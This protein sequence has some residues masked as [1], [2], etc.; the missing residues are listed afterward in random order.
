[1]AD[2][3]VSGED[4]MR[5][6][7]ADVKRMR[8]ENRDLRLTNT[9]LRARLALVTPDA[10]LDGED[11]STGGAWQRHHLHVPAVRSATSSEAD[12]RRGAS[13][14]SHAGGDA[15]ATAGHTSAGIDTPTDAAAGATA[16]PTP[17]RT[18]GAAQQAPSSS[19][20]AAASEAV[21]A[22][23]IQ[24]A[25]QRVK[26]ELQGE[27][28]TSRRALAAEKAAKEH[29][30]R[31]FELFVSTT[32]EREAA[33][34]LVHAQLFREAE[35]HRARLQAAQAQLE[36]QRQQSVEMRRSL[37][38]ADVAARA[39]AAPPSIPALAAAA[40]EDDA[41]SHTAKRRR[42]TKEGP[43]E[44]VRGPRKPKLPTDVDWSGLAAPVRPATA[45]T[46]PDS[47]SVAESSQ[48][49]STAPRT[50]NIV[51][52]AAALRNAPK[53][54]STLKRQREPTARTSLARVPADVGLHV[55]VA[56]V[57]ARSPAAAATAVKPTDTKAAVAVSASTAS[58][59]SSSPTIAAS[60]R[61]DA[62][63]AASGP[64]E[65]LWRLL[66][67]HT[68]VTQGFLPLWQ[69]L[70]TLSDA[71]RLVVLEVLVALLV[72]LVGP[73]GSSAAAFT[74][75]TP[76]AGA[77]MPPA[78]V[79]Q[80][81][82]I[83]VVATAVR[84]L[85]VQMEDAAQQQQQQQ[86]RGLTEAGRR[87]R[88]LLSTLFYRLC[89]AALC[90]WQDVDG[91]RADALEHWSAAV[92]HLYGFQLDLERL[93]QYTNT[94]TAYHR[95]RLS[96]SWIAFFAQCIFGQC[97][98]ASS[99][100][101]SSTLSPEAATAR[102][103]ELCDS[104]GWSTHALPLERL[105]TAA[106]RCVAL[107]RVGHGPFTAA[108]AEE[109]LLALRLCILYEGFDHMEQLARL[110]E[111]PGVL[112][113]AMT[114]DIYAELVSL[115]VRDAVP[116]RTQA[117]LHHALGMLKEYVAEAAPERCTSAE[118][119]VCSARRSH[120]MAALAL[121]GVVGISPS[122]SGGG[123]ARAS[124]AVAQAGRRTVLR[125][126]QEQKAAL[127]MVRESASLPP[128]RPLLLRDT[129]LGRTLLRHV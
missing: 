124:E 46:P 108:C 93:M 85:N 91:A 9:N 23:R 11:G 61:A 125:W 98:T 32:C 6:L 4:A 126:L 67:N 99:P 34:Q 82:S 116:F 12:T 18:R 113:M 2:P 60:A 38:A 62:P 106:A 15:V 103:R 25:I 111:Q 129:P 79:S 5:A 87:A 1:M 24:E 92:L 10:S 110:L 16:A 122:A 120:L 56:P 101:L 94:T 115:A 73:Q 74:A 97:F 119:F 84:L 64:V 44:P 14:S 107:A 95:T 86:Q 76:A 20:S 33:Y 58:A 89:V 88:V 102:W 65:A 55:P 72:H 45:E 52:G 8:Q 28:E 48:A 26:Q 77:S 41:S 13:A 59:L 118:H 54:L 117:A 42:T 19:G 43:S 30:K 80:P 114:K 109:A 47:A 66:A 81:S 50:L 31:E 3:F 22:A 127:E 78:F 70:A 83:A 21:S 29:L 27:L 7:E 17:R 40:A 100:S 71:H 51:S 104:V 68:E 121:L 37:E 75:R 128:A 63:P 69:Q 96:H 90:R 35:E 39:E 53:K 123:G 105:E 49:D 57:F 112:P 36:E